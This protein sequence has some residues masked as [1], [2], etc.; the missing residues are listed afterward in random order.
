MIV[1]LHHLTSSDIVDF[2]DNSDDDPDYIPDVEARRS[3]PGTSGLQNPSNIQNRPVPR[4]FVRSSDEESEPEVVG[5][6]VN[7][8]VRQRVVGNRGRTRPTVR[9][10]QASPDSSDWE[11]IDDGEDVGYVNSFNFGEQSGPKHC[12]PQNSSPIEYFNLFFSLALLETF[13]RETNRFAHQFLNSSTE[14]SP[15]SRLPDWTNVTVA[16]MKG[17]ISVIM[18]MG[19]CQRPSIES[20]W[21]T[22]S[23]QSIQWFQIMFT[24]NHFKFFS[25][26]STLLIPIP[27]LIMAHQTMIHV[28]DS[29]PSLITLIGSSVY[30][31]FPTRS[32]QLMSHW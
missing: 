28:E 15:Q 10:R 32:C 30:S 21:F 14:I 4:P 7:R 13:V 24:R 8:R 11:E 1:H 2:L 5:L 6:V 22:S 27:L 20:Y 25:S 9:Q 16:E 19:L 23:S 18:N 26:F 12:P 29:N 17:F 3:Q 31:M